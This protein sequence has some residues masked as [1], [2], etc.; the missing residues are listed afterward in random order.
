MFKVCKLLGVKTDANKEAAHSA[1]NSLYSWL[2][3]RQ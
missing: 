3:S 2:E 1:L